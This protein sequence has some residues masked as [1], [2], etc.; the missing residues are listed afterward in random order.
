MVSSVPAVASVVIEALYALVTLS[1]SVPLGSGVVAEPVA[2]VKAPVSC[3]AVE[4]TS[5]MFVKPASGVDIE[6]LP[7]T[8]K[9]VSDV[10]VLRSVSASE[11]E[12][13]CGTTESFA[14]NTGRLMESFPGNV[15]R[16]SF[17]IELF[18]NT[19]AE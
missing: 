8:V 5:D 6:P 9:L 7:G 1:L 12:L 16:L 19:V 10:V 2:T 17:V 13:F 14:G 15:E 3:A 11:T 18:P 4:K